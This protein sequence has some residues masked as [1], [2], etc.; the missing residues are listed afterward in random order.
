MPILGQRKVREAAKAE[1]V[2]DPSRIGFRRLQTSDLPVMYRWLNTPHVSKW[3]GEGPSQREVVEEYTPYIAGSE[4]VEPYLILYDDSPIGYIQTYPISHDEEYARLV[5]VEDSAGVD[6]F[7]GEVEY[8]YRG[9][10]ASILRRFLRVV[11]FNN[12]DVK[13]CVIGPEPKNTAA[14]RAY[15]KSGFRYFKTIQVPGEPEPEH[16]MKMSREE[17]E[18]GALV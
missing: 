8:L 2:L 14:V 16:L 13:T 11:V 10:G 9:L 4:P 1:V 18:A 5:D 15:E 3:Y 6:L 7:I 12:A 17:F